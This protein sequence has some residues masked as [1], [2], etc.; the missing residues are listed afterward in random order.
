MLQR[1]PY[2]TGCQES[3]FGTGSR[4]CV[5]GSA[6]ITGLGSQMALLFSEMCYD[7]ARCTGACWWWLFL[8]DNCLVL[9]GLLAVLEPIRAVRGISNIKIVIAWHTGKVLA[10]SGWALVR[11][12]QQQVLTPTVG[13]VGVFVNL[14]KISH[15]TTKKTPNI[16]S[17]LHVFFSSH[18][19]FCFCWTAEQFVLGYIF[20]LCICEV[21][22]VHY[23]EFSIL[24]AS[25]ACAL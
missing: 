1:K 3:C 20:S 7:M 8:D 9:E 19:H 5:G 10:G 4:S 16:Q 12:N 14:K 22:S 25:V 24:C 2:S 13:F 23:E 17:L 6:G 21:S 11:E 18:A 15:Q